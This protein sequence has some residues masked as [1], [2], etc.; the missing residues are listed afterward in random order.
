MDNAANGMLARVAPLA[1]GVSVVIGALVLFTAILPIVVADDVTGANFGKNDS[2]RIKG[3][4]ALSVIITLLTGAIVIAS[5]MSLGSAKL[6]A[7]V[8][9]ETP[10]ALPAVLGPGGPQEQIDAIMS[11]MTKLLLALFVITVISIVVGWVIWGIDRPK[12]DKE[13]W[14]KNDMNMLIASTIV[15]FLS[16][17][18]LGIV[19]FK[20]RAGIAMLSQNAGLLSAFASGVKSA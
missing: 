15:T 20:M 5:A 7:R 14:H 6:I 16:L 4:R 9:K 2:K 11:K 8:A 12:T 1:S 13:E 3:L 10:D 17:I 19:T 18:A